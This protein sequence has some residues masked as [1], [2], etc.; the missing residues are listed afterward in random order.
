MKRFIFRPLALALAIIMLLYAPCLSESAPDAAIEDASAP[1]EGEDVIVIAPMEGI[2]E[3]LGE[4]ELPPEE[5]P[6]ASDALPQGVDE[7]DP[8]RAEESAAGSDDARADQGEAAL[9][10]CDEAILTADPTEASA[11]EAGTVETGAEPALPTEPEP[12]DAY[13]AVNPVP[14]RLTLGVKEKYRLTGGDA[15]VSSKPKVASV[16]ASGVIKAKKKGKAVI[17]VT[18]GGNPVGTCTVTVKSAPKKITLPKKATVNVGLTV[19]LTPKLKGGASNAITWKS[20]NPAVATVDANGF[21]TG[22]GIGKAKITA[23][24]YNKKKAVCT[25][26]VKSPTTPTR[27][28]FPLTLL[29]V[30]KGERLQLEPELNPG[31]VATFT[32]TTKNKKVAGVGKATGIVTGKKENKTTT[33]TVRTHNGKKAS[34]KDRVLNAPAS[35]KLNASSAELETDGTVEL[36]ATLP[37]K[38]ASQIQWKSSNPDVAIV[39][40]ES[41]LT[42]GEG[43]SIL[44]TAVASGSATITASTFNGKT[45][46]CKVKVKASASSLGPKGSSENP[47][48]LLFIGN[49][50][51]YVNNVP[52]LVKRRA[53]DE[54]IYCEVTKIAEANMRLTDH[55]QNANVYS[56]IM[57]GGYDYVV[58]QERVNPFPAEGDFLSALQFLDDVIR[59]TGAQPVLY[60]C[61]SKKTEPDKQTELHNLHL[62]AAE[63]I[64]AL[65]APVGVKWWAYIQANPG[66]ELYDEDQIHASKAGSEFAAGV[67]WETLRGHI[68]R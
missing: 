2:Y 51:T 52:L 20:S 7:S 10:A 60:E 6:N 46:T 11:P 22:V 34:M 58:L 31:A 50:H 1:S 15:Y 49:S 26:S 57:R 61:W 4:V 36:I 43:S 12:A 14:E 48:K 63:S 37:A 64:Q 67:I 44:V 35:V 55:V 32:Y 24:T 28:S 23:R 33:I 54:K 17:T 18:S 39:S 30:G 66:V 53:A 38:S 45:A 68:K 56:E 42:T 3:E 62:R 65:L 41:P 25:V 29:S 13:E 47:F 21:V 19:I 8:E 16:N 9:P 59:E 40:E 5:A 27:V